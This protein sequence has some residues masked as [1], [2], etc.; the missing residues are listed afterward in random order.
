[1]GSRFFYS[2]NAQRWLIHK[3][4]PLPRL[5]FYTGAKRAVIVFGLL[6]LIAFGL[7]FKRSALVPYRQRLLMVALSLILVP[8]IVA[9][10]KNITNVHCPWATDRYGGD[11]PYVKV[12]EHYPP[13][14]YPRRVGK[15]FP[16]GHPTGGFALMSLFFVFS[17][18]KSQRRALALG[19]TTGWIMG[20]FQMLKGAHFLS[21]V[22]FSMIAS[23]MVILGVHWLLYRRLA[24]YFS[25]R[26]EPAPT[27][28]LPPNP[29][30][31]KKEDI[32]SVLETSENES[33]GNTVEPTRKPK[34]FSP[35]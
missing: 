6:T 18:A 29:G 17:T 8:T 28:M 12:L 27:T 1:V 16:A 31:K 26:L 34:P 19:L 23:W 9:G 32:Q 3:D 13:G 10:S 11:Q 21:H 15:C 22:I 25:H 35:I 4:D 33:E 14:D 30:Q 5:F 2:Q 20:G 7:S 24:F